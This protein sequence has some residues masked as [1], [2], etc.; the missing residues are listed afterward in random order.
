MDNPSRRS[1]RRRDLGWTEAVEG[2]ERGRPTT[3]RTLHLT[4]IDLLAIEDGRVTGR[5]GE[6][7]GLELLQQLDGL[8]DS[9]IT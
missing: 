8:P 7:S 3:H 5:W 4:G 2:D 9:S 1:S 6:A